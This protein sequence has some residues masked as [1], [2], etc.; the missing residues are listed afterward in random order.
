VA[1]LAVVA[2]SASVLLGGCSTGDA[3]A[4]AATSQIGR[5]YVYGG[6]SPRTGFDCS[7]LTMWAWHQAGKQLPRTAAAQYAATYPVSASRIRP[8]D[9]AFYQASGRISHVAMYIGHGTLVQ[10][11]KPGYPVERQHVGW[12]ADH[13]AGYRRLR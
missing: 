2:I 8:G 13:F 3:A 4:R 11:R 12:W 10:A 6:A 5:P 9:L 1:G 7:G